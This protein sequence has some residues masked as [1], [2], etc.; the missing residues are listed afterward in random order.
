MTS[1]PPAYAT[2]CQVVDNTLRGFRDELLSL[3]QRVRDKGG[4][5]GP[6][7][8]LDLAMDRELSAR[9]L[10]AFPD[11]A[12]LSEESPERPGG[13]RIWIVDPID[14]TREVVAGIPEWAVS[15]G[16]WQDGRPLCGWIYNPPENCLWWGGPGLGCFEDGKAVSVR[17]AGRLAEL[18]VGV[19]RTDLA[20]QRIPEV[21]PAP[22]GIGS[23]AY[24]LGLVAGGR[25]DATVSVT[26]KNI[27][28]IAGGIPLVLGAGGTVVRFDD[29]APLDH[30]DGP[31]LV[32]GGLVAAHP[33]WAGPLRQL[34]G[35]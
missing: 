7:T 3:P 11:D 28:D 10:D 22:R 6:L 35:A 18:D 12:W 1:Q 20:K 8:E 9:L 31:S 25:I 32:E 21:D 17:H 19:S 4:D 15:V 26:P 33:D 24:K 5:R 34:Y 16:L 13:R 23:I 27:W 2:E 14:G 30:W 29:G